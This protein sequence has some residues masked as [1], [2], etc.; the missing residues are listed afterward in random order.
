MITRVEFL[1]DATLPMDE[2]KAGVVFSK[3]AKRAADAFKRTFE[4]EVRKAGGDVGKQ[5]T[6]RGL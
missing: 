4:R 6:R 5:T 3:A 1:V 2:P